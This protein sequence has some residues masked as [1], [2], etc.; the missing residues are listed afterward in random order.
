MLDLGFSSIDSLVNTLMT[1]NILAVLIGCAPGDLPPLGSYYDLI[2]RLWLR[3]MAF[4][5]ADRKHLYKFPKNKKPS[6]KPGKGKKLPNRHPDIVK[7]MV[8][9]A[10]EDKE[11]P[12]HYEKLLQ[13][14]F[15]LIAVVPS[16]ELGLIPDEDLTV[17]GDGTCVHCHCDPFGNKVCACRENGIFDCKCDRKFSDPD[18]SYGWDSDLS[19]WYFGYTL[20]ML[21]TYNPEYHVDLPLHLRFLD[22]KRHDSVGAVVALSEFRKLFPDLPIKNLCLDSA[23]D[24]YPTYELCKAWDI[25]PF[26]D[27]NSQ[28]GHPKSLPETITFSKEGVPLCGAGLKMVYHG[29][30]KGRSRHKWR[31]PA[32]CGLIDKCPLDQPC[33]PSD[34]GRAVYTKPDWD[35]KLFPPVPRDSKAW[36]ETY[37][38]RTCSER[39]N[40]R[41]LNDYH[42][43]D[44]K[45]RGKKRY[46][47]FAMMI[48]INIHLDARIKKARKDAA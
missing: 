18:A 20:Y 27:L 23:N 46:S 44:M 15:S 17:A 5:K 32:K 47:F 14:I 40:N 41:V 28:R 35:I 30:C 33:S 38:A 24:N 34:Y 39:I 25:L 31:C 9:F 11:L 4:D 13:E 26:I 19:A 12:F 10:L 7:K 43:H 42:L 3:H 8:S 36:K 1:D 45:I 16:I 22:A 21:A 29:F 48:G 6:Q 2:D 37:S